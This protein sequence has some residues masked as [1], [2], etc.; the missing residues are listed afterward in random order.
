MKALE[1]VTLT[2]CIICV[3]GLVFWVFCCFFFL[4]GGDN[5]FKNKGGGH[6]WAAESLIL[7]IPVDDQFCWTAV[8]T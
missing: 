3:W 4:N 2:S 8:E 6:G 1:L 7:H 5:P